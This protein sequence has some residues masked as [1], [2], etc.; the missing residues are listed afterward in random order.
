MILTANEKDV[1]LMLIAIEQKKGYYDIS[2]Y[3]KFSTMYPS[4][5]VKRFI[6]RKN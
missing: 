6:V 1:T 5:N 3:L 2:K 4:N